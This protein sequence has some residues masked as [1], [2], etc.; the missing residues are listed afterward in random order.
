MAKVLLCVSGGIAVYKALE[1]VRLYVKGGHSVKV[2]MTK[3]ATKFV[4][5]LSFQTLSSSRVYVDLFSDIEHIGYD[6]EIYL[7][8]SV[9]V[10]G[11]SSS[12]E[13]IALTKWADVVVVAPATYNVVGKVASGVADDL[14]STLVAASRGKVI[15]FAPSMNSFMM[16]NPIFVNNI[17]SLVHLGYAF[18]YG[19]AGELA[20]GDLGSGR[21]AEP[22]SI[23]DATMKLLSYFTPAVLGDSLLQVK[24][25]DISE[26]FYLHKVE[27]YFNA[28][29]LKFK[30]RATT[31]INGVEANDNSSTKAGKSSLSDRL[32]VEANA[33]TH[34]GKSKKEKVA[35]SS[36][37]VS[38]EVSEQ[39]VDVGGVASV[40]ATNT[41]DSTQNE[42]EQSSQTP[43]Y[44][45]T[46]DL[47]KGV[48][49]LITSG[50]THEY[51][52]A[53]RYLANGSS[54]R[55]GASLA[56]SFLSMGASVR[57]VSG[58]SA[59]PYSTGIEL[60]N[61]TSA[62]EMYKAVK[63]RIIDV[64][65][66]VSCAA[67]SDYVPVK[68][69]FSKLKKTDSLVVEFRTNVDILYEVC[70]LGIKGLYVV[71]FAAENDYN[72]QQ[73]RDKMERKGA[74]M[75]FLNNIKYI[76]SGVNRV[77]GLR[78]GVNGTHDF[79]ELDKTAL[80]IKMVEYVSEGYRTK[81]PR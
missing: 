55:M 69:S 73:A 19:E 52:D 17:N 4:A 50:S 6:D 1:L 23:Y 64:D 57:V 32:A 13:H 34:G 2:V 62:E 63:R 54:G 24:K 14:L 8:S 28:S 45:V 49:V 20:C 48:R 42:H 77:V 75:L 10:A 51:I 66:F 65:I 68:R 15:L 41:T 43:Q 40:D 59:A 46:R 76:G 33:K 38:D 81:F 78:H 5:P 70:H 44:Q 74:D 16:T 30:E 36:A 58:P 35:A 26:Y 25:S 60:E 21:L 31:A 72:E 9:E 71:G 47:F 53:V 61:V 29:E 67:V 27:T 80:A 56:T 22:L 11:R 3:S 39:H 18:V 7:S 37:S 12:V 79:G